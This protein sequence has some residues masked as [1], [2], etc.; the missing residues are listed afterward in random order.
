MCITPRVGLTGLTG[1]VEFDS[2]IRGSLF[3]PVPDSVKDV[4]RPQF[5]GQPIYELFCFIAPLT[6]NELKKRGTVW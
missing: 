2:Q 3:G 4:C 5:T 1:L 6:F